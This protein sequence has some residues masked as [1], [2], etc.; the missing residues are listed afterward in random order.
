MPIDNPDIK[1]VEARYKGKPFFLAVGVSKQREVKGS[2]QLSMNEGVK[3]G[4]QTQKDLDWEVHY[5]M[6]AL[7]S[8]FM[9]AQKT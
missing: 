4:Y 6:G 9:S 8:G 7:P 2:G 1:L 5:N 3:G